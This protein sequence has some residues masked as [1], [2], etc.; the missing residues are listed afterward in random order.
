MRAGICWFV[1]LAVAG[2][3][4][5]V[6]QTVSKLPLA[7]LTAAPD[8]I[9][10]EVFSA[11]APHDDPQ[12]AALWEL[13]DEQPL[14]A[15][16]RRQLAAN[17]MRAG[18]VGPDVPTE[19]AA[20]LKV[21]DRRVEDEDRQLVSMDPEG[22]VMMRLLHA[23]DGKRVELAIPEVREELTLLEAEDGQVRGK[24]YQQAECRIALRAFSETD[25]RV[26]LQLTPEMPH[27][28]FKGRVRGNDGLFMLTQERETK[29]FSQ[30]RIEPKLAPGQMLL[31]TRC[32]DHPKT[33]GW[34]FFTHGGGE[35]PQAML[36]V[37]RAARAAPDGAFEDAPAE[38]PP[39]NVLDEL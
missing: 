36:W 32:A 23:H 21:T 1:L 17:G 8:A 3:A 30:L 15:E 11:P 14:P 4:P 12:F 6:P 24:T 20:V 31:V 9:A 27:G 38:E 35:K 16:L 37:F 39:L 26:R 22:G 5:V 10:L 19:L 33:A 25:G 18:L 7:P 13:V 2:C 29:V 28:A 34:H